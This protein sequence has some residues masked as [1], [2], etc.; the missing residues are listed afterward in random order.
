M[1][2]RRRRRVSSRCRLAAAG[3]NP[4]YRFQKSLTSSENPFTAQNTR[5][6]HEHHRPEPRRRAPAHRHRTSPLYQRNRQRNAQSLL[7]HPARIGRSR[8]QH[9]HCHRTRRARST[10]RPAKH[11][12]LRAIRRADCHRRR[13]PRRNLPLRTRFQRIRFRRNP[14][15]TR[16]QH[17]HRQRH[18]DHRKRRT[19][20]R[21]H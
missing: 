5:K 21:A 15:R 7:P 2:N 9:H 18:P 8:R 14:C 20:R 1:G 4:Q 11:G 3:I 19:S 10:A 16:L 13:H 6:H 12:S 17:P